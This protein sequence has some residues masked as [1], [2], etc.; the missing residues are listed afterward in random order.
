MISFPS[1]ASRDADTDAA[2]QP[3][4]TCA[5]EDASPP[6][7]L[8]GGHPEKYSYAPDEQAPA[9][10][11]EHVIGDGLVIV[12][13][14]PDLSAADHRTIERF[15]ATTEPPYVIAAPDPEQQEPVRVVVAF[16]SLSCA[17]VVREELDSFRDEW[18]AEAEQQRA[19]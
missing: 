11:L 19:G 1:E 17:E 12:R 8:A 13:Y 3:A 18:L 4:P 5:Q 6:R 16:R 14:R 10:D 7:A 2:Q 15:V 9:E